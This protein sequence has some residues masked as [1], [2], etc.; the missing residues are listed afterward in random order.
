[1]PTEIKPNLPGVTA[2]AS[3]LTPEAFGLN[4]LHGH[5]AATHE[6]QKEQPWHRQAAHLFA[7][8]TLS[9]KAVAELLEKEPETV[10]NLL[11]NGWFQ[12]RVTAIMAENGTGA[13]VMALFRAEA[14]ASLAT[15]IELRDDT[16]C[17][18]AVRRASAIDILDRGYGK[19][20]IFVESSEGPRSEDPVAERDRLL[21][22][23]E[24]LTK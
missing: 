5:S 19:P 14:T 18:K 9:A 7:T 10:R 6:V 16:K 15:L 17:P 8:G 1:M 20:K 2:P 22:E 13:D 24:R 23:N 21:K 4:R 11:K 12:E 3:F